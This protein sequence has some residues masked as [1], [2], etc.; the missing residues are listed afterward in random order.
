MAFFYEV[1]KRVLQKYEKEP[2]KIY[3]SIAYGRVGD[4]MIVVIAEKPGET[5]KDK[6]ILTFPTEI[7]PAP[8][9]GGSR[10]SRRRNTKR[11]KTLK[12]RRN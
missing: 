8:E 3:Y 11:S 7:E 6:C 5:D 12:K 2:R 1:G 10:R 4:D 9:P